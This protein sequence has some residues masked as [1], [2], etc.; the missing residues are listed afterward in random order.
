MRNP[1]RH[2]QP[3]EGG[4]DIVEAALQ[5]QSDPKQKK[6]PAPSGPTGKREESDKSDRQD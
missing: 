3:A 1:N 5:K 4:R 6:K 2:E